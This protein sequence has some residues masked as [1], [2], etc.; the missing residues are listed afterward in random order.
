MEKRV[1]R[2]VSGCFVILQRKETDAVCPLGSSHLIIWL[3]YYS[4]NY[5]SFWGLFAAFFFNPQRV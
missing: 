1:S 4:L 2:I 3:R 5:H